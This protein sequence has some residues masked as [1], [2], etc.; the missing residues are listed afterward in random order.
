MIFFDEAIDAK[1]NRYRLRRASG[2]PH[3]DTPF[4][5][6]RAEDGERS[7]VPPSPCTTSL[8]GPWVYDRFPALDR[9][10]LVA[11]RNLAAQFAPLS[12]QLMGLLS[13]LRLKRKSAPLD[14]N[15]A[16]TVNPAALTALS[17][18]C[19]C[20]IVLL[21]A[22]I[23]SSLGALDGA[24]AA[25]SGYLKSTR[26]MLETYSEGSAA[27]G[28]TS[29]GPG[30]GRGSS[31]SIGNGS[32][33]RGMIRRMSISTADPLLPMPIP[34]SLPIAT[35]PTAASSSSS[36]HTSCGVALQVAY[37]VLDRLLGASAAGPCHYP[38]E[39]VYRCLAEACG[40]L[41]EADRLLDLFAL[42]DTQGVALDHQLRHALVRALINQHLLGGAST[43]RMTPSE[44][45]TYTSW[46]VLRRDASASTLH[47]PISSEAGMLRVLFL[48]SPLPAARKALD[49]TISRDAW[50][51]NPAEGNVPNLQWHLSLPPTPS[52]SS[53][54]AA[55]P[56]LHRLMR[57]SEAC[58]LA[59]YP[60]LSVDLASPYMACGNPA[61]PMATKVMSIGEVYRGWTHSGGSPTSSTYTTSCLHCS[62]PFIPRFSVSTSATQMQWLELL[63]PWVLYKEAC[64][65]L[66]EGGG[67]APQ[68]VVYW[69]LLVAFRL[70]G[71]PAAFLT[72]PRG[73]TGSASIVH[74]FPPAPPSGK[75]TTPKGSTPKGGKTSKSNSNSRHP[76]P[77]PA[78]AV[79]PPR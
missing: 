18:S 22:V 5:L 4:L 9:S 71:L 35:T 56:R 26:Y 41:G 23:S 54:P 2:A 28:G 53:V 79:V 7:Y 17:A 10:L 46:G 21:C 13:R 40:D 74:S 73:C 57:H 49:P 1:M 12:D 29:V 68:G 65:L 6:H 45:W 58:L 42:M 20:Y 66:Y 55:S 19:S 64:H 32:E 70:R 27:I 31:I 43:T 34:M 36:V 62:T 38:D 78:L 76:S 63:S 14:G 39:L 25:H 33:Q 44:V 72:P 30:R 16:K 61:C 77:A 37:E 75:G 59:A 48:E 8:N 60:C 3:L 69:N 15:A 51:S 24:A 11:P 52:S 47:I 67:G 50:S